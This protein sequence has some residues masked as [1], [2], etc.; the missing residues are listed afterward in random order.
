ME[1]AKVTSNAT[2]LIPNADAFEGQM[3][4]LSKAQPAP[5]E[6]S[7]EYWSP[8]EKGEKRRMFFMDLRSEK[9]IDE[10]SGQDIDL[11]V[12][13]FVEPVDGRKRVVRQAS[14][15]LTAVFEN[16]Q[17]TIRPGMAFEITYLGK[18]RNAT[19]SFMSDRWAIVPLKV[20]QQ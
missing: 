18:E 13:Y 20:E 16:F 11:L 7:S 3:P 5:L 4:D 15:R 12:A 10:Q 9:S 1:E 17:K 2:A 6:I 14:R 19:N 8:K